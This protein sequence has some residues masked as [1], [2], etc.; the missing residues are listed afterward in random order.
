MKCRK[1][2]RTLSEGQERPLTLGE[3]VKLQ[4]HLAMCSS[5]RNFGRQVAFL[6]ES[7]QAYGRRPDDATD[8]DRDASQ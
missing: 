2:T 1:A 8:E 4:L 6:R 5:C 7:M 3:K